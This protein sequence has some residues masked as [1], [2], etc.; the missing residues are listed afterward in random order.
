MGNT[1]FY[2]FL[3][4]NVQKPQF[5]FMNIM[6]NYAKIGKLHAADFNIVS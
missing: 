6:N 4:S 3:F 5:V 2:L 1:Y